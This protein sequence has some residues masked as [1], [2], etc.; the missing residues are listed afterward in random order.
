MIPKW[1]ACDDSSI[2]VTQCRAPLLGFQALRQKSPHHF[3]QPSL[4][5]I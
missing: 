3:V 4:G 1:T 2:V 5:K